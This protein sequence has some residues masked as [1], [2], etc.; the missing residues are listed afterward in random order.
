MAAHDRAHAEDATGHD[1]IDIDPPAIINQTRL[2][3]VPCGSSGICLDHRLDDLRSR[4]YGRL[5]E[6]I[7]VIS[8]TRAAGSMRRPRCASMPIC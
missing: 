6:D 2:R 3:R 4:E 7:R 1:F 8:T 5:D